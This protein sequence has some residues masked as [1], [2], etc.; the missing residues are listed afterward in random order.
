VTQ[1]QSIEEYEEMRHWSVWVE[2]GRPL[3]PHCGSTHVQKT[4]VTPLMNARSYYCEKCGAESG[5]IV[6]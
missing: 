6:E 4:A 3:C 2:T 1:K 5:I